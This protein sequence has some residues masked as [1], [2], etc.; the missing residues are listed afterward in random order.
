LGPGADKPGDIM[1]IIEFA[2]FVLLQAIFINGVYQA[3]SGK[4]TEDI[5]RGTV[6]NGL[7]LFPIALL[8]DKKIK[9]DWI[10][11]PLYK[12]VR[13]MA[14]VWGALTY[15]PAVMMMFGWNWKEVP[16]FVFDVFILVIVN[17]YIYK[18]I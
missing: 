3:F 10:K 2:V 1:I 18:K 9:Q 5:E 4:C 11:K 15:W 8:M 6:C 16:V 14:S 12:C 13:C 7:L 17:F